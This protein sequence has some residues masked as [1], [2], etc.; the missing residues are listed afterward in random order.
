[1]KWVK[2]FMLIEPMG[3]YK[4]FIFAAVSVYNGLSL[5]GPFIEKI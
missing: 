3:P 2:Y 5:N 1:M 4:V